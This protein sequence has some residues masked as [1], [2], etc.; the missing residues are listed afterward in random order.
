MKT[1]LYAAL[2]VPADG[3]R[4]RIERVL[5]ANTTEA[6]QIAE[7]VLE[8]GA[9]VLKITLTVAGYPAAPVRSRDP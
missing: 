1:N 7:G 6:W 3:C 5:A 8:P 9:Q 4:S 2:V